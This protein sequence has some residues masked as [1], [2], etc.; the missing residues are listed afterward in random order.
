MTAGKRILMFPAG[1]AQREAFLAARELGLQIVA[2]DR[3]PHASCRTLADEFFVLDPGDPDALTAFALEYHRRTPLSGVLV[4]GC[5]IPVSCARVAAALGTPGLSEQAAALTVD[6]LRMK[7]V[8]R[9]HGVAVPDFYQVA[10]AGEVE[11]LI[12]RQSRRM[13]I[14]PNDNSGAR[15]VQQLDIDSDF[16]QAF[17]AAASQVKRSGVILETFEPGPQISTEA[18][19]YQ[20]EIFLTGFADR[21]YE[22][23]D[24]FFPH[25]LENGATLPSSLNPAQREEVIKMFC[26][27]IRALGIDNGVAKG[28]MVY[29]AHGAKVIE[30]A[31]RISGGKFASMIVPEASGVK[32]LH[33]ALEVAVGQAPDPALLHPT[34]NRGV[35][36]R[37][38]FPPLGR[39]LAVEGVE[40]AQH[41][42]GV[43]ELVISYQVGDVI[44][45]MRS[46]PDR[47]GWV[48]CAAEDRA[49][50]VGRAEE[51]ISRVRFITVPA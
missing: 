44:G 6:K 1:P 27:G 21:N 42:P 34:R 26:R 23:I 8:L 19:I 11:A 46:H 15:G 17:T 9:E 30:I 14:K 29:T 47:G 13:I 18:L 40:Q 10:D 5:D 12:R 28:D 35:A 33:A 16:V 20:G 22:Y 43:L 32:L 37:Y 2:V 48:V 7:Q 31:G 45:P 39:L 50:A 51:A 24:H 41:L 49:T 4:V 38:M 3:D 25:V 36:V